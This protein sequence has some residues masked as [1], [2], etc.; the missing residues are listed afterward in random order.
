VPWIVPQLDVATY[1]RR[2]LDL[3]EVISRDGVFE[4]TASRMLIEAVKT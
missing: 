3:H 4:T 1:R 2:L